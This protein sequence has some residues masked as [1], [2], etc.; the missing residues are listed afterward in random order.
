VTDF[1]AADHEMMAR[2]LRL[3]RRGRYSAHPNPRVGCVIT[4]DGAIVGEGWHRK[5]GE[6]HAEINALDEAGAAAEG[7]TV[8]V[9]LEPCSHHGKTPPCAEALIA[10]GVMTVIAAMEDP[11]AH[12]AGDGFERLRAAGIEVKKG[13]L[14]AE[15]M[16]LNEGFVSRA[17]R[18]R[19]FVRLKLAASLDGAA[20]MASGESQWIT[21]AEAREDV[22]KL[23]AASG[24]VMTGIGTVIADD[25]S[26][27]VRDPDLPTA[28]IQ[29]VRVVLDASLRMP[30]AAKMLGL[31]GETLVYCATATVRAQL[32]KA[33]ATIIETASTDGGVAL[34][35]VLASLAE[36]GVNDVLVEA[37]PTLSG[38]LLAAE[39]V[40]ELVIYQAPH[41]MGSETRRLALTPGWQTLDQR[42]ALDIVDLRRIGDDIRMTA[43]PAS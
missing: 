13:L 10:A 7:A 33:G 35:P 21:G 38:A 19:P 9:T 31:D 30:P 11:S 18:G 26:L 41:I 2:A 3:A 8:Y 39:L 27:T 1:S 42:L 43:R 22:Q 15:A 36:R 37:G 25:P 12:V 24:A 20:A 6:A 14:E 34:S 23:R 29:P 16:L 32:E 5:T 40:D 17:R 28:G 4:R